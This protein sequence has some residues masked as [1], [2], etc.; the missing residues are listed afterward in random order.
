MTSPAAAAESTPGDWFVRKR[1]RDGEVLDCFVAAPDC[2]GMPYDAE[3]LGDDEYREE[4]GGVARKLADCVLIVNAVKAY[5]AEPV[6]WAWEHFNTTTGE[7]V[8][9]GLSD[10]KVEPTMHAYYANEAGTEWIGTRVT[11]LRA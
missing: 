6:A 7:V 1:E 8:N 11:P 2:Q 10:T 3:I 4:S 5:R 9:K